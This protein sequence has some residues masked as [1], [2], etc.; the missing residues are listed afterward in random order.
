M[1]CVKEQTY[2]VRSRNVRTK[3]KNNIRGKGASVESVE[4][5]DKHH[6]REV[7]WSEGEANMLLDLL[8]EVQSRK[9]GPNS[10]GGQLCLNS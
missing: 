8:A 7:N 3:V 5:N 10:D 6:G 9:Q 4:T 1:D 2:A